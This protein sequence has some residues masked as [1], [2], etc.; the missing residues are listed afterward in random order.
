M[1]AHRSQAQTA[2]LAQ[3]AVDCSTCLCRTVG[4][5]LGQ[6]R[7]FATCPE[8]ETDSSI[9]ECLHSAAPIAY[10]ARSHEQV[11][12]LKWNTVYDHTYSINQASTLPYSSGCDVNA[13]SRVYVHGYV[14]AVY[15]AVGTS[16]SIY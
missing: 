16:L 9:C 12:A 5:A 8:S 11:S 13:I 15:P 1:I 7:K 14:P 2:S 10:D 4:R 3:A 6:A